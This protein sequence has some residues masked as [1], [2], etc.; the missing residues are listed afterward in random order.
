MNQDFHD[1][2]TP[3]CTLLGLGEP[4]H[5]EPAFGRIR[6]TLLA[7]LADRGF[8]SVALETDRLA[9]LRVDAYVQGGADSLDAVLAEGFSHGFGALDANRELVAW[10]RDH[11]AGRPAAERLA[12]HGFDIPTEN[13]SA[14]SPRAALEHVRAYLGLAPGTPETP[15]DADR[16]ARLLGDDEHWSRQEAVLD[17]AQSPGATP[18]AERARA[19]ADD[20]VVTLH[21]RAPE[22]IAATSLAAWRRAKAHLAAAIGLL[23]YHRQCA[24][25]GEPGARITRLLATRDA[26]M[27]ENLLAV[28]EA[29]ELRGP[30]LVFAHN[31]HLQ[32]SPSAWTAG[33]L[34]ATWSS[35]GG[36]V[37]SLLGDRYVC[38]AGSVGRSA[39]L[40][41][42][43]PGPDT[44][45]GA[46][47]HRV[48]GWGTV[49]AD[50]VPDGRGRTGAE[51][52]KGYFPL[53]RATLDGVDAVLH[54]RDAGA[55]GA[56]AR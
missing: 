52:A 22:L 37:G 53:D 39:A 36:I 30:T 21:S 42:T 41:L 32:R 17:A 45:E 35:A 55:V 29:E 38:V 12:F 24:E 40:G 48:D 8:R 23:R 13:Y 2:V 5:Q 20:L 50:E 44:Y 4:T 7:G 27:A 54:L 26:L 16:F 9:A 11:N 10:M 56:S 47:Q 19:L 25:P 6:N 51:P 14:P 33:E 3:S 34:S 18:E 43:D 1:L 49:R 31:L 15:E 28:R 46:L